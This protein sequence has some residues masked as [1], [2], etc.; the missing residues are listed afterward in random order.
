VSEYRDIP[1]YPGY[2][3]GDDGS[4]WTAWKKRRISASHGGTVSLIGDIWK[5]L[6]AS[7]DKDGYLGVQLYRNGTRK[8][9][10]IHHLVLLAFVGARPEGCTQT[11]HLDGNNQN[12]GRMNLL[13]G[14]PVENYLD[15]VI[16]GTVVDNSGENHGMHKLSESE[17]VAIIGL[18]RGGD[19]TQREIAGRFNVCRQTVGAIWLGYSWRHLERAA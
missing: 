9:Y 6:K 18:L 15:R 5:P 13:W 16:H 4:A 14:G 10:Q 3:I 17:V 19:T 11:R 7:P 2:R 12:N 1:G 8:H